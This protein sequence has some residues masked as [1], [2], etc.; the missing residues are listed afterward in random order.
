V[1]FGR[2]TLY[3]SDQATLLI[4]SVFACIVATITGYNL[5]V[6]TESLE[7]VFLNRNPLTYSP[8]LVA[9]LPFFFMVF[10]WYLYLYDRIK[11]RARLFWKLSVLSFLLTPFV[12][13]IL[14]TKFV[15]QPY[16]EFF[17][18]CSDIHGHL[19]SFRHESWLGHLSSIIFLIINLISF[20]Y[21]FA[22]W[23]RYSDAEFLLFSLKPSKYVLVIAIFGSTLPS[24][25]ALRL[26]PYTRVREKVGL[27]EVKSKV[28]FPVYYPE[29]VSDIVQTQKLKVSWGEKDEKMVS[30]AFEYIRPCSWNVS[31]LQYKPS[32]SPSIEDEMRRRV[33]GWRKFSEELRV[34]KWEFI[35]LKNAFNG[36]GLEVIFEFLKEGEW[37][38]Q[39]FLI[40]RTPDMVSHFFVGYNLRVSNGAPPEDELFT[41]ASNITSH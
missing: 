23:R 6:V 24:Y 35:E 14:H 9:F 26:F 2:F 36:K 8:F 15:E 12:V 10:I 19:E 20:L 7:K 28:S 29:G 13:F 33:E 1:K 37:E 39:A 22:G 38:K 31:Y 32:D 16:R 17:K 27:E 5:F 25:F 3:D 18:V 30:T 4:N 21:F 34:L 41:I 11:T 40:F